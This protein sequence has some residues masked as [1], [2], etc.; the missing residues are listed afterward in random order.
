MV[1]L[2]TCL[3]I[4]KGK[5]VTQAV[6]GVLHQRDHETMGCHRNAFLWVGKGTNLRK[7]LLLK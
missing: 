6:E 7:R 1:E 2:F 4:M 3:I 5:A